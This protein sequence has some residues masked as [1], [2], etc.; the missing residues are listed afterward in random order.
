MGN[1]TQTSGKSETVVTPDFGGSLIT[2]GEGERVAIVDSDREDEITRILRSQPP[3]DYRVSD[4]KVGV[5][6]RAG[7][8]LVYSSL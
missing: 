7:G 1:Q 2:N 8:R 5:T 3:G 6:V 4:W